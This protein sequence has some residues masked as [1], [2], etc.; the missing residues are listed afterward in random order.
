MERL[1]SRYFANLVGPGMNDGVAV[2]AQYRYARIRDF[3][4]A[5]EATRMWRSTDRAILEKKGFFD[6]LSGFE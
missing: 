3:S 5:F 1:V 2:D 4:S 6:A